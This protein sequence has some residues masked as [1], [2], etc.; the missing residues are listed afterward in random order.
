M[1]IIFWDM[2]P[3]SPFFKTTAVKTSNRT[4]YFYGFLQTRH[5]NSEIMSQIRPRP[6]PLTPFPC[7]Y[8]LIP[9]PI[10]LY[11]ALL[12]TWLHHS[13]GSD[14]RPPNLKTED[15]IMCCLIVP[16]LHLKGW[17]RM[18]MEQWWSDD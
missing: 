2:T 16:I 14:M 8:L 17:W 10:D 11:F 4:C 5:A 13:A 3:C 7:R 6:L 1:S 15:V 18:S 12:T 9:I